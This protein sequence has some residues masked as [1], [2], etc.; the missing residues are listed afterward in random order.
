MHEKFK[1]FE[2]GEG[3]AQKGKIIFQVDNEETCHYESYSTVED[4]TTYCSG[5]LSRVFREGW[6]HWLPLKCLAPFRKKLVT[7]QVLGSVP[8]VP[9]HPL[10]DNCCEKQKLEAN[11]H[12]ACVAIDTDTTTSEQLNGSHRYADTKLTTELCFIFSAQTNQRLGK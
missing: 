8:A 6:C 7:T 4:T 11:L 3:L 5:W 1:F 12:L 2:P 10:P 9:P